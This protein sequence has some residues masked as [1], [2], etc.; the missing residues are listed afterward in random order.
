MDRSMWVSRVKR[1]LP[2]CGRLAEFI[3]KE[4]LNQ[5]STS[6]FEVRISNATK[7]VGRN[8]GTI[9][10]QLEQLKAGG[11]LEFPEGKRQGVRRIVTLILLD[12]S[13]LPRPIR[14]F[15]KADCSL[16]IKKTVSESSVE[17]LPPGL[18]GLR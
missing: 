14:T 15:K 9:H 5:G 11:F 8:R 1:E 4:S 13:S 18:G 16:K 6:N 17:K 2:T 10:Y 7:E 3:E 12:D